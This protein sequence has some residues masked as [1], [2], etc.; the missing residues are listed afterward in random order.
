ML[1]YGNNK[2]CVLG[3]II[4][5]R[6]FYW[7]EKVLECYTVLEDRDLVDAS[8]LIVGVLAIGDTENL[9]SEILN[10]FVHALVFNQDTGIEVD[11]IGFALIEARVCADLHGRNEGAEWGATTSGEEHNLTT[12]SSQSG[13]SYEVVAWSRKQ[14]EAIVLESI[15]ILHHAA[16]YRTTRLLGATKGLLF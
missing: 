14:V 7:D 9:G 4:Q 6:I 5:A 8:H 3:R 11:P 2:K 10:N 16:Y 12:G 13:G 1:Y 15:A